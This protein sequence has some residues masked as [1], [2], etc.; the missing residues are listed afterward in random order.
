MT[1]AFSP[2]LHCGRQTSRLPQRVGRRSESGVSRT[3]NPTSYLRRSQPPRVRHLP[4]SRSPLLSPRLPFLVTP[5][6]TRGPA[7]P[8]GLKSAHKILTKPAGDT[9][10][11]HHLPEDQVGE[12]A[13]AKSP[14]GTLVGRF[15]LLNRHL[16][17]ITM[18]GLKINPPYKIP[19]RVS[20]RAVLSAEPPLP[21][22]TMAGLKTNPPYKIRRQTGG[23]CPYRPASAANK[24]L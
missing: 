24:I 10:S 17:C 1:E 21:C 22:I 15:C 5:G 9:P 12:R 20:G 19:H 11:A 16:L 4:F 13:R 18:A 2:R 8:C 23:A 14:I 7:G 3:R 6:L